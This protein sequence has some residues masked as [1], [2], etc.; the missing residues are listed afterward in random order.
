MSK[1]DT[2]LDYAIPMID[3][4]KGELNEIIAEA[5]KIISE[6]AEN[7]EKLAI[8]YLK[9]AQCLQKIEQCDVFMINDFSLQ[10][11]H[12][13]SFYGGFTIGIDDK[14]VRPKIKELLEKALELSPD[15]PEALMRLGTAYG[16]LTNEEG[17]IEKAIDLL[18]RAIQLK[19]DYAAAYNNRASVIAKSNDEDKKKK[20]IAD[21]SEAIRIRPFDATYFNNRAANYSD[22]EMREK[23]IDDLSNVIKYGSDAF[24]K[25]MHIFFMRAENYMKLKD[26]SKAID[27]YSES[28]KL[29]PELNN[30]L[31]LRG[32]AYHL[33][34]EKDKANADF[35]EYISRKCKDAD[36]AGR[37]EI[38]KHIGVI[39]EGL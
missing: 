27:D 21:L 1:Y 5:D 4:S 18:T 34:G 22:L 26:Y 24:K 31:L 19:S 13:S 38:L 15:M 32:K 11:P 36:D 25:T 33:A 10:R 2:D 35:E 7:L 6:S 9:K 8:A 30:T 37:A 12:T 17:H 20:A 23:A 29:E 28:L 14:Q 3:I 16:D 39:P